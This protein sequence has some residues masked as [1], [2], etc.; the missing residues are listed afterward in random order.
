MHVVR[1]FRIWPQ[2]FIPSVINTLLYFIIFGQVLGSRI[3]MV[4]GVSYMTYIAPGLILMAVIQNSYMNV[5]STVYS[6]RWVRSIDEV[7]ASPTPDVILLL[8]YVAGGVIRAL[9]I[10]LVMVSVSVFF[11][12][13][14]QIHIFA[15]FLS[16]FLCAFLF[17][18]AGFINGMLAR[19]FDDTSIVTTFV[20]APLS[21]LG[22]VFYDVHKLPGFWY[23]LSLINP[24]HYLIVMFR[25]AMVGVSPIG[26]GFWLSIL[27][28]ICMCILLFVLCWWMLFRGFGIKN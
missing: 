4:G 22:G 7:I 21:Y 25:Y 15:A 14:Q 16:A 3:G 5:V 8:G 10:A 12:H 6:H 26:Y 13:A 27:V 24:V 1:I 28:V 18:L 23:K 9:L 11:V 19:S 20:L 17:S 2:T